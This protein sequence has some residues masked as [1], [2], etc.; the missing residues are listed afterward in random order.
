[1]R[2]FTNASVL[3][4]CAAV[5]V[6]TSCHKGGPKGNKSPNYAEL[7]NP[8]WSM[9]PADVAFGLVV[10]EGTGTRLFGAVTALQDAL[11]KLPDGNEMTAQ[12]HTELRK[13]LPFD[14][15]DQ[16]NYAKYGID[17][18]KGLAL[19]VDRNRKATFIVPLANRE[20]FVTALDGKTDSDVDTLGA[21]KGVCKQISTRYACAE[22][23]AQLDKLG[24]SDAMIKRM[25]SLARGHI[26]LWA[27]VEAMTWGDVPWQGFFANPG[28]IGAAVQI[29][30]GGFTARG[31]LMA[32]PT[33]QRLRVL[34]DAPRSLAE[35][36]AKAKPAGVLRLSVPIFSGLVPRDK[37]AETLAGTG[38]MGLDVQKDIIDNVTGEL[39]MYVPAGKATGLVVEYGVRNGA[40]LRP[41]IK[42]LCAM[43]GLAVPQFGLRVAD[44]SC[45]AEVDLTKLAEQM[46]EIKNLPFQGVVHGSLSAE[47]KAI[48]LTIRP[49]GSNRGGKVEY[50]DLAGELTTGAWNFASWGRGITL[51][52]QFASKFAQF[53]DQPQM[54]QFQNQPKMTHIASVMG[55][56]AAHLR[57]MGMGLGVRSDGVHLVL[58][59]GT[60]FSNSDDVLKEFQNIVIRVLDG[61][62]DAM[63][64]IEKLAQKHPRSPLGRSYAAGQGGLMGGTAAA[65]FLAAIAIP[66]FVKYQKKSKTTEATQFTKKLYD[67]ARA[68]YFDTPQLDLTPVAPHFPKKSAG[69]TPPLGT[70]CKQGGKCAP[71]SSYW[72]KE[73]WVALQFSVDDPHFYSYQYEVIDPE[74][75]FVVRAFGDLDCDGVYSTFEMYG[76][77][78]RGADGPTGASSLRRIDELE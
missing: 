28:T 36:A 73:P 35:Q 14:P 67:G 49:A 53:P 62:D 46:P 34:I 8:L 32:Q 15:L 71:N 54:G 19:F 20:A 48:V 65:G 31:Q 42:S 63:A 25:A 76:I 68:H 29:E 23:A 5:A 78:E 74:K 77:V 1:M 66:T 59:L 33:D 12:V 4:C 30:R 47:D 16:A 64:D 58:H 52:D 69:P 41:A 7:T 39:V 13:E 50:N 37:A 21:G 27:N 61:D 3:L 44:Q 11:E 10:A 75:Q 17:P 43:A 55:W 72:Q 9:A 18:A 26:E 57:E 51:G 2:S 45:V 6:A 60:Q 24:K 22:T 40:S 56:A 38:A 70:C